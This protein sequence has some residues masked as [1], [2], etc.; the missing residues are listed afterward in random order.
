MPAAASPLRDDTRLFTYR[1]RFHFLRALFSREIAAGRLVLS[2]LEKKLP[3]PNYTYDTLTALARLCP[4]KPVLVIGADQAANLHRWY[5]GEALTREYPF[6]IFARRGSTV[7]LP[8]ACRAD[9][10]GDFDED[11]SATALR[12]ALLPL[13]PAA[14]RVEIRHMLASAV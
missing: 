8:A 4:E 7:A 1:E 10:V 9:V 6:V 2:Q 14:R 3:R 5:K 11:I 13:S 12:E